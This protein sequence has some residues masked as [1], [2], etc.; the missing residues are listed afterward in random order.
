[1][2]RKVALGA[3]AVL[4]AAVLLWFHYHPPGSRPAAGNSHDFS[5]TDLQGQ[6]LALAD[7]RG[8][9]VLLDFWATWCA[10]CLEEVPHFV[11]LQKRLGGDGLQV[12]GISMDDEP[13]PV[14]EFYRTHGMN[15]PVALGDAKLA[16]SYGGI[17]GLPVAFVLDRN[18]H[19][20]KKF[21]GATDPAKIEEEVRRVLQSGS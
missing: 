7:Y 11:D 18:G 3:V 14:Q 12:I 9:V 16:E 6:R 4:F 10:P 15:Y 19:I 21:V 20:V 13:K 17:L 5:L 8:K 2:N 1:M